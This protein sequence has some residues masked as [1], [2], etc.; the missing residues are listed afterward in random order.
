MMMMLMLMLM[1][2]MM[3]M[4]LLLLMLLLM[5][6]LLLCCTRCLQN[7]LT[8]SRN[9]NGEVAVFTVILSLCY[10]E[11]TIC[12]SA[13]VLPPSHSQSKHSRVRQKELQRRKNNR[14][15]LGFLCTGSTSQCGDERVSHNNARPSNASGPML[16]L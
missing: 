4:M 9:A 14:K 16:L 10:D 3:V 6:V 7:V 11:K 8:K 2:M 12:K 15:K 1:L 13:I 5:V